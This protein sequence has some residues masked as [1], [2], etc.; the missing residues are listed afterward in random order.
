MSGEMSGIGAKLRRWNSGTG[1]WENIANVKNIT[2]PNKTRATLDTTSLDTLG[3][4]RTFI[5]GLRDGGNVQ[6]T[7]NF[8]RGGYNKMNADF[9]SDVKQNYEIYLSQDPEETSFEF[10]G[11]VTELP[12]NISEDIITCQVTIKVSGQV[13]TDSGSGS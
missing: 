10:E 3:G 6:F 4:Y 5:A 9:E 11:L 12:L 8:T 13:A 7:L 2:G 1:Q